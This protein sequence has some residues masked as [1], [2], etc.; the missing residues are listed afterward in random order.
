MAAKKRSSDSSTPAAKTSGVYSYLQVDTGR[1]QRLSYPYTI[2]EISEAIG[3][4]KGTY[5]RVLKKAVATPRIIARMA[6]VFRVTDDYIRG[7]D[8]GMDEEGTRYADDH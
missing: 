3:I 7:N 6:R 1:I 8:Y 5:Y 4:D 2:R